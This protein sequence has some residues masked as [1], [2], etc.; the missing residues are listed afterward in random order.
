MKIKSRQLNGSLLSKYTSVMLLISS[1]SA[2]AA[3]HHVGAE[4]PFKTIQSAADKAMPGDTITV[5][6]GI[7]REQV[8]P[9][10]GGESD[11]K[12]I[13]YQAAENEKVIITGS[14]KITDW[15][16]VQGDVWKL[17]IPNS[18]F[19]DFN[20]YAE[21]VHGDWFNGKGRSH[22]RGNIYLNG[23]WVAEAAS[24]ES[25]LNSNANL[26]TW[27]A[28]VDG[29]IDHSPNSSYLFNVAEVKIGT[30]ASVSASTASKLNGPQNAPK[31]GGGSCVGY[32][33]DGS[34]LCLK[35][36]QFGEG[37]ESIEILTAA[38]ANAGGVIELRDG[39]FDGPLLGTCTVVPTG[40]WQNWKPLTVKIKKTSGAKD[41]YLVFKTV[42]SAAAAPKKD[43]AS[44]KQNT[45]ILARFPGINPNESDV[46][47]CVRPTVFTPEKTNIN[48]ITLRGFVLKNAATN[49]AAPTMGQ[50]G[51]VTAYW[52][53]G[54]II[55]NNEICYSRCGGIALG[56]YS[57]EWDGQRGTTEGYYLTIKDAQTTGG[58]TKEN[59]G[60]HIVRNNHIH[61]CGQVGIVG[62]LGCA[63]SRIE[64][65]EIH[66]CNMQGIWTGAEMAG[67]KFHGALDTVITGNHFY[68]CGEPAALWLDWM[69][70]GTQITNNLFH[71]NPARDI[72]CEV[73]HG[74]YLIA[75]NIMLSN[76]AYLANS[77]GGAHA[78]NLVTGGL[79]IIADGRQTPFMKP[80]STETLG[81]HGCP[82][83]DARWINNILA[84]NCN[85][86]VYDNASMPVNIAGNVYIQGANPSKH[87]T[88]SIVAKEYN[89]A[90]TLVKKEDG[91]YLN[92]KLDPAWQNSQPARSLVTTESLGKA[93]IPAAPFVNPDG[94]RLIID[95]DYFG[96]KRSTATPF[97]GPFAAPLNGEIKIWPRN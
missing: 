93:V 30:Q 55:E 15:K 12:R 5:H 88:T 24:S 80:H 25:I 51:L 45:T 94:S 9:P 10:R 62:S 29:V 72:F 68:R 74:P 82:I 77:E 34:W 22:K 70:Q 48:Y 33:T 75:N 8:A 32:I 89:P 31:A 92:A 76:N 56:K 14:E 86:A 41:L 42:K 46:E 67:I 63:F 43:I 54:W 97:P 69:T 61:H 28:T 87:D 79:N 71:D 7:Y 58:W 47:V 39:H 6:A 57:D 37:S 40:D 21:K 90:I 83:G 81:L 2:Y 59:I 65:N 17:V 27:F 52:N 1:A 13:T 11:A 66:D 16:K 3:E 85:L 64:G 50:R 4:H 96:K 20:P 19:G 84:K 38:P 18:Y 44:D 73:N 36:I 60:S 35:Q 49:W 78:H 91:W 53:K 23:E 26:P 95:T